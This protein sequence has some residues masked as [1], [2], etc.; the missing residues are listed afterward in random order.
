M[1]S[2]LQ[3]LLFCPRQCALI[4]VEQQWTENRYTAEGRIMHER[5]DE[6]G[7]E[8]RGRI[9]TVFGL[10]LR[11]LRLGL[12]GRA[13]A[14]EYHRPGD[15][16]TG[17]SFWQPFPVEFKRGKPKKNDSD[18]VQLCAQAICLEEMLS[19]SVPEG[20]I[21]YGKP[22]RRMAVLFDNTLREETKET[23]FRLHELLESGRTPRAR[24]EKKCDSCSL[25]PLC[26]PK[27]TGARR[28]VQGYMTKT[29]DLVP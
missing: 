28:S 20:A 3:H 9:R 8:S 24:Y 26:M 21:Y 12:S 6:A 7:R 18:L 25:L 23:A 19:C 16:P 27:I 29:L 15:D 1:I 13:D 10:S 11:S 14:V 5:V 17:T 2:A 4:H 22:R